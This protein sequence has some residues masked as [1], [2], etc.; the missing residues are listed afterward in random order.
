MRM[1][2]QADGEE[3]SADETELGHG[4]TA[5]SNTPH[6]T[7]LTNRMTESSVPPKTHRIPA[8]IVERG[9]PRIPL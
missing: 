3:K 4:S 1:Q 2:S 9:W 6:S 7:L 5:F 8:L